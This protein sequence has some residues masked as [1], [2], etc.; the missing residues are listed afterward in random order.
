MASA[1]LALSGNWILAILGFLVYGLLVLG[2][3]FFGGGIFLFT[4][5][6]SE[7]AIRTVTVGLLVLSFI[8]FLLSGPFLVGG[9]SF[10]YGIAAEGE[11]E[12]G[13]LFTGFRRFLNSVIVCLLST[14]FIALWS[15][16][17]II[18]GI[19]AMYRYAMVYYI[20][21]AEEEC[22]ALEAL[23]RSRKMMKGN[24]WRFF[25]LQC[26]FVGLGLLATL[27]LGIGYLW[28]IP[29]MKATFAKFYEDVS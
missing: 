27:T 21:A 5:A 8:F 29:Y 16:L 3:L 17:L 14:L 12:L 22:G 4:A 20:I 15:I 7:N 26:R 28:L 19:I 6:N 24:K 10:F 2:L 18:P 23:R 13:R 11:V 1:R 9:C 25:G